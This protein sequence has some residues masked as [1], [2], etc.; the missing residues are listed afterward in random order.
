MEQAKGGVRESIES[1]A[2]KWRA[3]AFQGQEWTSKHFGSPDAQDNQYRAT[4]KGGVLYLEK[5]S[6]NDSGAYAYAGVM[7]PEAD[8][9][10][11]ATV[12]VAAAR[13]YLEKKK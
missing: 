4:L 6:A 5:L 2:D 1:A 7:F 11:I 10:K 13:T 12:M 8:A 3:N 9:P